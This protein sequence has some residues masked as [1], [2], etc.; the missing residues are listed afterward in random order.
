MVL[1]YIRVLPHSLIFMIQK[2]Q[3]FQFLSGGRNG[4]PALSWTQKCECK[5]FYACQ[6]LWTIY[7]LELGEVMA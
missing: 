1:P 7:L 5:I 4:L 6:C 3:E 2:S